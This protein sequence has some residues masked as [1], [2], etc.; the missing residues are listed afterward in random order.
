MPDDENTGALPNHGKPGKVEE[1]LESLM[2]SWKTGAKHQ[3]DAWCHSYDRSILQKIF[4]KPAHD[5]ILANIDPEKHLKILDVGCGTGRLASRILS[6]FPNTH[7]TGLDLS[8][9]MLAKAK[10]NCSVFGDRLTL[11]EGDSENLPFELGSF[12]LAV[13]VHSFHHYPNQ[14]EVTKELQRVLSPGGMTLLVDA[15]RD[16]FLGWIIFDGVVTAIEKGVHHCSI[17]RMNSLFMESGFE[18][19]HVQQRGLLI[20]YLL[21]T[22]TI[23]LVV[24]NKLP[25]RKAA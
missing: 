2:N 21:V 20:P 3:F 22:A 11:V 15:N 18:N 6:E 8:S 16:N 14:L 25:L 17:D 19:I 9:K 24:D 7:V 23:P 5:A 1:E 13:C 12:D 4:F 10:S